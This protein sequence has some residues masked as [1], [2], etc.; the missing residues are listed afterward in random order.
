MSVRPNSVLTRSAPSSRALDTSIPTNICFSTA[1]APTPQPFLAH[2]GSSSQAT[3]RAF[4]FLSERGDSIAPH[5]LENLGHGRSTTPGLTQIVTTLKIQGQGGA[6]RLVQR[7]RWKVMSTLRPDRR[8]WIGVGID[9]NLG[10]P[11][12][13]AGGALA[14]ALRRENSLNLVQR[15]F[16]WSG[17]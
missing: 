9:A 10:A 5:G 16:A 6:R 4:A 8:E 14:S 2:A 7:R 12:A 13:E 11:L 1:I 15:R 3:V 17:F